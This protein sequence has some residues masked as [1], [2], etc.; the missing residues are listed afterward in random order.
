MTDKESDSDLLAKFPMT[1]MSPVLKSSSSHPFAEIDVV[2]HARV[3]QDFF[4]QLQ[5]LQ[6]TNSEAYPFNASRCLSKI[7]CSM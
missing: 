2:V 7:Y 5:L 6:N 3:C 4:R 1:E